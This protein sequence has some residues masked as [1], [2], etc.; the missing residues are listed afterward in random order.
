MFT[1]KELSS[2]LGTPD[3]I[4]S[5]EG[6]KKTSGCGGTSQNM[7]D[8]GKRAGVRQTETLSEKPKQGEKSRKA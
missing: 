4:L 2:V 5:T 6:E 7:R 8:E 1:G 3:S